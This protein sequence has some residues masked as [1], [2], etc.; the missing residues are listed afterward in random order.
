M[1]VT[2]MCERLRGTK[3]PL[4]MLADVV[5]HED[6]VVTGGGEDGDGLPRV[7]ENLVVYGV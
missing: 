2:Q 4:E 5:S 3:S 6:T 7:S 1:K